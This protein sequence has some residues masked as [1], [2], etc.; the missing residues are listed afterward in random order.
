MERGPLSKERSNFE[1]KSITCSCRN[2]VFFL[3]SCSFPSIAGFL[4]L[5]VD[6]LLVFKPCCFLNLAIAVFS[7]PRSVLVCITDDPPALAPCNRERFLGFRASSLPSSIQLKTQFIWLCCFSF[8]FFSRGV[9]SPFSSLLSLGLIFCIVILLSLTLSAS[10]GGTL[11][12]NGLLFSSGSSC[13]DTCDCP[14]F[15]AFDLFFPD[16]LHTR[17]VISQLPVKS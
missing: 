11:S 4:A 5:T 1:R 2:V 13:R 15:T 6:E 16:K 12:A 10:N 3:L 14:R 9:N 17:I 8:S 7:N